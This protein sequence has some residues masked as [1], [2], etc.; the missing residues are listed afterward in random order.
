M[1]NEKSPGNDGFSKEFF[2][3]FWEDLKET[4]VDSIKEAKRCKILS[5]SQRQ[6]VIKLLEKK[7]KIKGILKIGD[8]YLF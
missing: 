2:V 1:K 4:F 6:A 3:I 5:I 7:I 8:L